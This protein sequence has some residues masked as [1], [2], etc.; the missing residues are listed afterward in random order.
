MENN[1]TVYIVII[2]IILCYVQ[3]SNQCGPQI[4]WIHLRCEKFNYEN[5][6]AY[7]SKYGMLLSLL[8]LFIVAVMN[9]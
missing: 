3:L 8:T 7:S 4:I 6:A 5:Y 2:Q 1:N 9:N